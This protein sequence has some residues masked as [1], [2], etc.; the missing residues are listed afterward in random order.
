MEYASFGSLQHFLEGQS[1]PIG[2]AS[3]YFFH[4]N[5]LDL[6]NEMAMEIADAIG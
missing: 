3:A 2:N 1:K 4:Q 6:E 5:R